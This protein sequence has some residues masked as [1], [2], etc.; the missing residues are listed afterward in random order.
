[1][2]LLCE[3]FLNGGMYLTKGLAVQLCVLPCNR[4]DRLAAVLQLEEAAGS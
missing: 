4:C 2:V 1:M 3:D